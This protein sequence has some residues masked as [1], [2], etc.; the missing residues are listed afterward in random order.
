MVVQGTKI[1]EEEVQ[2]KTREQYDDRVEEAVTGLVA[3]VESS[4]DDDR[5]VDDGKLPPRQTRAQR[6]ATVL[7][8]RTERRSMPNIAD[9]EVKDTS[10]VRSLVHNL[11][12]EVAQLRDELRGTKQ[13]KP[14]S[15]F[16]DPTTRRVS[17]H[18]PQSKTSKEE[19]YAGDVVL[20]GKSVSYDSRAC[21]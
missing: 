15:S 10:E 3:D 2:S 1:G 17:L 6:A 11:W 20:G 9:G 4:S 7:R 12:T 8:T 19:I 18:D 5:M 14:V 16:V 13:M 21:M